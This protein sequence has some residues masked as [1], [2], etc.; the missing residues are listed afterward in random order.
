MRDGQS[1]RR[2]LQRDPVRLRLRHQPRGGQE[3]QM[4]QGP[5]GQR[6]VGRPPDGALPPT[7]RPFCTAPRRPCTTRPT[8]SREPKPPPSATT[9]SRCSRRTPSPRSPARSSHGRWRAHWACPPSSPGS[10]CRTATTAG[11]RSTTWRCCWPASRSRSRPVGRPATTRSTRTTSSR[12]CRS[13]SSGVRPGDHGQLVRRADRQP[14]GVV[15]LPRLAG[16][17]GTGLRGERAGA[18]RRPHR[19]DPDAGAGRRHHGR[20]ARRDAP[21]G[22]QVPPGPG[23]CV[24]RLC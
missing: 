24:N 15:R 1:G 19:R 21:D 4:G 11:G 2:G 9:T 22:R 12:P 8:T 20:L 7:Q 18:A 14:A 10:T 16:R 5:R 13:C 17:Q 6:G 23:R 3:R